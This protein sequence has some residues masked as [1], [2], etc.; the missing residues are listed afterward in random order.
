MSHVKCCLK[1]GLLL[2]V[3]FVPLLNESHQPI[4]N[5]FFHFYYILYS[6][7]S[8]VFIIVVFI[9]DVQLYTV[10]SYIQA[11]TELYRIIASENGKVVI[12]LTYYTVKV[13]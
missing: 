13:L 9:L 1:L 10:Y 7:N 8:I 5:Y 3:I 4:C 11:Y 6:I 12:Q 2:E